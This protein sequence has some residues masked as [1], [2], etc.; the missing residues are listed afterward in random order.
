MIG[1]VEDLPGVISVSAN[2]RTGNFLVRYD[3]RK[4]TEQEITAR[5]DEPVNGDIPLP[6]LKSF[7]RTV[8]GALNPA[9]FLKKT[10]PIGLLHS[11]YHLSRRLALAS[12][13]LALTVYLLKSVAG[14][15][16]AMLIFAI[17]AVIF[18]IPLTAFYYAAVRAD[19]RKIYLKEISS[20]ERLRRSETVYI[21]ESALITGSRRENE[22]LIYRN[23]NNPE[24]RK[25]LELGKINELLNIKITDFVFGIRENGITD[26]AIAVNEDNELI[27]MIA[28]QLGV[29]R[30]VR[31]HDNVAVLDFFQDHTIIVTAEEQPEKIYHTAKGF[32]LYVYNKNRKEEIRTEAAV[33]SKDIQK[34][35]W[36]VGLS[37]Y[38][39]ELTV[40]CENSA[41]AVH[42]LGMLLS[43]LGYLNPVGALSVYGI[44]MAGQILFIKRKVL[45]YQKD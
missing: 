39:K 36:L 17:P 34:I 4:I 22:N 11:E 3:A 30:V 5:M 18:A 19:N 41:I 29:E 7:A 10:S 12:V 43:A 21:H 25:F 27:G 23:L 14:Q 8:K 26:I 35:P 37:R 13:F 31:L 32:V 42:S 20:L 15:F 16:L 33:H 44:N 24:F 45:S 9:L 1:A 2:R 38:C 28:G 40:R 6:A